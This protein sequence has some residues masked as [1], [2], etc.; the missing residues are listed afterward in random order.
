M[1]EPF[2][3]LDV[4]L[5]DTMQ[6]ETRALLRETRATSM[7]VTHHPEE[8]M[9]LADR[10]AVMHKGR[11]AQVGTAEDLY[12]RPADLFVAR[13]FS[14]V[15]EFTYRTSGGEIDTPFGRFSA[16]GLVEGAIAV[17]CVRER[18]V[19]ITRSGPGLSGR[20]L[21]AKFLGDV[22]LLEIGVT[23]FDQPLRVRLPSGETIAKGE[24]VSLEVD[25]QQIM[26]FGHA[27]RN[28]D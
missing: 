8:A 4:Q 13:L 9:R 19:R 11:L 15:N 25:R 18:G 10:I 21:Q 7:I 14:E 16:N 5:R 12:N 17:L 27:A 2:S 20:V 23:G 1:D 24:D 3:G 6:E 22:R 26:V 28:G